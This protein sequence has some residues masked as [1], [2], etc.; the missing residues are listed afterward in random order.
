MAKDSWCRYSEIVDICIGLHIG[1]WKIARRF[2][3]YNQDRIQ[4]MYSPLAMIAPQ[5][6][7]SVFKDGIPAEL[8]TGHWWKISFYALRELIKTDGAVAKEILSS[9]VPAIIKQL[10]ASS[11]IDFDDDGCL[12]FLQL[13]REC[14]ENIFEKIIA[15]LDPQAISDSWKRSYINP[16]QKKQVQER[17]RRFLDMIK[18]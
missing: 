1:D 12:V 18:P 4:V 6:A 13:A 17:Y 7:V 10:N 15:I 16:R 9:N 3:E 5:C 8:L 11:A 14:D 2:V